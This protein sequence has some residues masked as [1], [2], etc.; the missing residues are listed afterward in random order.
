M[1]LG[2][3]EFLERGVT[4][5]HGQFFSY[6]SRTLMFRIGANQSYHGHHRVGRGDRWSRNTVL[7]RLYLETAAFRTSY[8]TNGNN[9]KPN[10]TTPHCTAVFMVNNAQNENNTIPSDV[11]LAVV[12]RK[13]AINLPSRVIYR[14]FGYSA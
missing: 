1:C 2:L 10:L 6:Q 8:K 13:R 12:Q 5:A 9:A 7:A 3:D 11:V 14:I 4:F